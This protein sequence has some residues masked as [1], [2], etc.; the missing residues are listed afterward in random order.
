MSQLQELDAVFSYV[1]GRIGRCAVS[2]Q[3]Q[4]VQ[5]VQAEG[6][7]L[8][9]TGCVQVVHVLCVCPPHLRRL[10]LKHFLEAIEKALQYFAVVL[11]LPLHFFVRVRT[12]SLARVNQREV[13]NDGV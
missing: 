12:L 2:Q 13:R 9:S 11:W 10:V 3:V 6:R 5:Q 8:Y 4:R 7:L 1:H